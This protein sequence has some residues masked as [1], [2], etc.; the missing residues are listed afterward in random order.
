MGL[1]LLCLRIKHRPSAKAGVVIKWG[2]ISG[3]VAYPTSQQFFFSIRS[4]ASDEVQEYLSAKKQR[5][6]HGLQLLGKP[7][8]VPENV[9]AHFSELTSGS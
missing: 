3:S 6:Q 1:V 7:R 4:R 9:C 5:N 2:T 8:Q